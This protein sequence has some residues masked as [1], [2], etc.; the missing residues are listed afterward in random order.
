MRLTSTII[1]ATEAAVLV[2]ALAAASGAQTAAR[3]GTVSGRLLLKN[4]KPAAGRRI[5]A[6]TAGD[7]PAD[8]SFTLISPAQT[9]PLGRYR[10][11]ELPPGRYYIAAGALE[12]L[13][14]FPGAADPGKATILTVTAGGQL[15]HVDFRLLTVQ[16]SG[17]VLGG[18]GGTLRLG[19]AANAPT[20]QIAAD[21]SFRFGAVPPG[22][23]QPTTVQP[24]A[25]KSV[26]SSSV[27]SNVVVVAD[28]DITGLQMRGGPIIKIKGSITTEGGGATPP[29]T[30]R[31]EDAS[32]LQ[33]PPPF[34]E[35]VAT[36]AF[37]AG[38]PDIQY[39]LVLPQPPPGYY[40]QSA[41]Q[42][43]PSG[44]STSVMKQPF[45]PREVARLDIVLG[46]Q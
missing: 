34:V 22:T 35:M 37:E 7:G 31:F 5:V 9:D 38:L 26:L 17:R 14:Y 2:S 25:N 19:S 15:E 32:P 39:R 40:L 10:L 45:A 23:Y 13:T 6:L 12:T 21:G 33:S 44:A 24:T 4:G 16:V 3:N 30:L 20:A 28:D 29:L 27:L 18:G 43:Y 42:I 46:R 8:R 36:A 11:D 41:T 1:V